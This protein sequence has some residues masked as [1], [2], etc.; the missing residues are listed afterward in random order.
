MCKSYGTYGYREN[1]KI[2]GK[3]IIRAVQTVTDALTDRCTKSQKAQADR[4]MRFPL[5][6]ENVHKKRSLT[7]VEDA[8][9]WAQ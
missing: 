1:K 9:V 3:L 4:Y 8:H 2:C 6:G 7:L 5:K